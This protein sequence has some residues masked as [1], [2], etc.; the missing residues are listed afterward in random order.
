LDGGR[1][2]PPIEFADIE[3]PAQILDK[4][5]LLHPEQHI[6]LH[7][8]SPDPARLCR[9]IHALT[10]GIVGDQCIEN[11]MRQIDTLTTSMGSEEERPKS[12]I[13]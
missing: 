10:H 9:R 11:F 13:A 8:F 4:R 5:A 2:K 3:R 1:R 6:D 12:S 7:N